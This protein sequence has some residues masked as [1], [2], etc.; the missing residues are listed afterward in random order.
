MSFVKQL[1]STSYFAVKTASSYVHSFWH[2]TGQTD[3]R[4]DARTEWL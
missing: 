3:G 2:N 4:T 1:E